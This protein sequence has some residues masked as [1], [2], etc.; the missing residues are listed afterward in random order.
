METKITVIVDNIACGDLA[1]E[2][3]LSLWVE[4]A[5]RKILVDVGASQLFAENMEKLGFEVRDAEYA[6]LSHAHYDHANGM[7][8]FFEKN[9]KADFF[10]RDAA[11][12]N[13]YFKA[14]FLKKY[15]GMPRGILSKYADRVKKVTGD[16]K[17]YEGAYLI[18][19][20][21]DGLAR[22]GRREKMYRKTAAGWKADDFA[23]E[24][25]L[26]L[27]T[28]KGLV[29]INCCSH[30][31]AANII[32]EVTETFPGKHVHGIIGGFHL[33]NKSEKEVRALASDIKR[34][35]IEFVC[36]GHCTRERAYNILKEELGGDVVSQLH[37]GLE[38]VF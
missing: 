17:M 10:I 33:Y 38:M 16:Y 36:T 20:K 29:I 8:L 25:S 24:Q 9:D 21:T 6:V 3:G 1:G 4:H 26:V 23:H 34:T 37:V 11:E 15:I 18:P 22:L 27:E 32:R 14:L 30:G 31:G 19:H 7:E 2:W 28:D 12:E 13:C 35:G 5:G